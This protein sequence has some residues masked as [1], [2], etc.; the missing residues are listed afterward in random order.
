MRDE[1]IEVIDFHTHMLNAFPT[2]LDMLRHE[3]LRRR[4]LEHG[5]Q[6]LS[7]EKVGHDIVLLAVL[8]LAKICRAVDRL[9]RLTRLVDAPDGYRNMIDTLHTRHGFL[10]DRTPHVFA[11]ALLAQVYASC[12]NRRI[13]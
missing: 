13:G 11:F 2:F 10:R 6:A 8:S 1:C 4:A 9:E 7:H 5:D 12:F 3:T